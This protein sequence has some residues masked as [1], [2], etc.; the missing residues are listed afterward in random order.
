V[1]ETSRAEKHEALHRHH[2][3]HAVQVSSSK[4]ALQAAVNVAFPRQYSRR[5]LLYFYLFLSLDL[6]APKH[7]RELQKGT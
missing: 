3:G 1:A 7:D 6:D 4:P 5:S 2:A